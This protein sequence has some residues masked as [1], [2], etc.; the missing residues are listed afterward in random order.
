M[1][2]IMLLTII[3]ISSVCYG[4]NSLAICNENSLAITQEL[5]DT[6]VE[7]LE[8]WLIATTDVKEIKAELFRQK[9]CNKVISL[10]EFCEE[11]LKNIKA[12]YEMTQKAYDATTRTMADVIRSLNQVT[13]A[14]NICNSL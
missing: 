13:E 10:Q 8:N 11:G 5:Y 2:K 3:L 14:E 9:Y 7:N 12:S 1:K 4:S 6:A